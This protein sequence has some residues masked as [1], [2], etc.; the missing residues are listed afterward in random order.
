MMIG[1]ISCNK[2]NEQEI[3]SSKNHA[4]DQ[5]TP[6]ILAFKAK[7]EQGVKSEDLYSIDSAVWYIEAT[8]NFT[9]CLHTEDD[10]EVTDY[11]NDSLI[12]P[13]T[14]NNETISSADVIAA[15]QAAAT[16]TEQKFENISASVKD[17]MFQDVEFNNGNLIVYTTF[18]ID[19]ESTK[20][21]SNNP[22]EPIVD[23]WMYGEDLGKCD[24]TCKPY[25]AA[26]IIS[27]KINFKI[28]VIYGYY[29]DITSF[30]I[31]KGMI[32]QHFEN[33]N[34]TDP[35]YC[36]F[37]IFYEQTM[38]NPYGTFKECISKDEC[39]FYVNSWSKI[40]SISRILFNVNINKDFLNIHFRDR[41]NNTIDDK[42]EIWFH[43]TVKYGFPH[44]YT[45]GDIK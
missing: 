38:Y 42:K 36:K 5:I 30:Y 20:S 44:P 2:E 19:D 39:D 12:I 17:I 18:G 45:G 21:C 4:K 43:T 24:G 28:P 37:Y 10:P 41:V 22:W 40:D 23:G 6:K 15:Y 8:L 16:Y 34:S 26:D 7:M 1:L 9:Y 3:L 35:N 13:V 14:V 25:D 27:S 11:I 33:P 31:N 32:I 29:T